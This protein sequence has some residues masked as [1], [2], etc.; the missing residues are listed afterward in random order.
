[1]SNQSESADFSALG[2][3]INSVVE[4]KGALYTLKEVSDSELAFLN[5]IPTERYD[6]F[7]QM[8]KGLEL[9]LLMI[10][11]RTLTKDKAPTR[12]DLMQWGGGDMYGLIRTFFTYKLQ[13]CCE[14][15]NIDWLQERNSTC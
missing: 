15:A 10:P 12:D 9:L 14:I 11:R 7:D 4:Y 13:D 1:M 6:Y 8:C 5:S 2:K 3:G